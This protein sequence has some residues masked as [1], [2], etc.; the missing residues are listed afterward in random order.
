LHR[1]F[2]VGG[3]DEGRLALFPQLLVL[4]VGPHAGEAIGLLATS[5]RWYGRFGKR[6]MPAFCRVLVSINA[7]CPADDAAEPPKKP[8]KGEAHRQNIRR[9]DAAATT[10]DIQ[11]RAG[12]RTSSLSIWLLCRN[13]KRRG[14]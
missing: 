7:W 5:S 10:K 8:M 4:A 2:E 13:G 1:T 11:Q 6:M 14:R 3:L 12:A 9:D